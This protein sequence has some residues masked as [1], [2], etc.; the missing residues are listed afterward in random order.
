MLLKTQ[1]S[2]GFY[3]GKQKEHPLKN[4]TVSDVGQPFG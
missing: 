4:L 1:A 3:S 2:P